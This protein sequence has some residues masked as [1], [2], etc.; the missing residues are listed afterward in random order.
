[1]LLPVLA[2]ALS[3]PLA[4][5][6]DGPRA[7]TEP[8]ANVARLSNLAGPGTDVAFADFDGDMRPDSARVQRGLAS[9]GGESYAI[10]F[11]FSASDAPASMSV[12]APRG[13]LRIEARD[14]NGD[15]AV[16]LVLTTAWFGQPV[17]ILLNDGHGNFSATA[18][19][20][21][22]RAF[23]HLCL[24]L[25]ANGKD[26]FIPFA[27]A[28]QSDSLVSPARITLERLAPVAL[29]FAV[30]PAEIRSAPLPD[31]VSGRAPPS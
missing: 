13:G 7:R 21:Y 17:A 8:Q 30:P 24:T 5:R 22:P 28:T 1:M 10:D 31:G 2:A 18:P 26:A 27:I 15:N 19:A 23:D 9:T 11:R 3:A 12:V 25:N 16:D 20:A 4:A 14:V 6:A 29:G